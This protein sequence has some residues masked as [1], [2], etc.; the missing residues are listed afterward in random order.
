M[1]GFERA[2]ADDAAT[3]RLG[4]A[5]AAV[6]RTGDLIALDGPLGAG[7]TTFARGFLRALGVTEE[8][9]SPTFTLVQ[10]Y[11]PTVG[12]VWHCD[13]YRIERPE[14]TAALGIEEAL[15]D[16]II[17]LEWPERMGAPPP[18]PRLD[19]RLTFAAGGR[20]VRLEGHGDW[21][22]RLSTLAD[23]A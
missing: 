16:A 22:A 3:M 12:P 9:P 20:R 8:V 17:L 19:V 10:I 14:D 11:E 6:S 4:A 13:L 2:L 18:A 5:A 21:A 7:K 15:D 23:D 1:P